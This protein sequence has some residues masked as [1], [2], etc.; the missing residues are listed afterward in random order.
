MYK[1][2]DHTFAICAYK[3][4]QY[5]E[6]CIK[7]VKN[8]TVNT[9]VLIVT[10]TP[11]SHIE[12]LA[13]KYDIPLYINTGEAGIAGDWNFAYSKAITS[14][15]T[16]THQDDI[17]EK[18]YAYSVL[19]YANKAKKPIIIFTDY[20]ELRGKKRVTKNKLLNVKRIM[21][22]PLKIK[23]FHNSRFVRRRV[24]SFG[25]PICCPSVCYV[26]E[27][28]PAVIFE[29]GF[30]SDLDWQAWE[31]LSRIRG[32]FVYIPKIH[33]LHRIHDESETTRIIGD[34]RRSK[35]DLMMYEKFWPRPIA[36]ALEHF[37]NKGEESNSLD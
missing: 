18:E 11:N 4:S 31:K 14:L 17:Y 10:S 35:E 30:F 21:L 2:C 9:K 20:G 19:T 33:M 26:K 36:R 5:L 25:S 7:S 6:D 16:I 29:K 3:E 8:Q 37:Y 24:L 28:C 27:S 22:L 12:G 23:A 15:V 32:A 13:K 34:N 1:S